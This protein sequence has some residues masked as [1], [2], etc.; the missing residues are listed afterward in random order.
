[1]Q[2][3]VSVLMLTVLLFVDLLSVV[4][5]GS[6]FEMWDSDTTEHVED[7][8]GPFLT[9]SGS[10]EVRFDPEKYT[11]IVERG[12][13]VGYRF[14][15]TIELYDVTWLFAWQIR[16]YF[17]NSVLNA[18]NAYYHPEEPIH[19]VPYAQVSPVIKNDY[20]ETHGYVQLAISALYPYYVNATAEDY[21]LGVGI[22]IME[23]E[24]LMKPSSGKNLESSLRLDNPSTM[25][26]KD[27]ST[28]ISCTKKNG[29][30]S[31]I[32]VA[33]K[34]PT[35]YATIQAAI[36]AADSGNTIFV[37]NGTYF[38]NVIINKTV[39]LFGQRADL[40]IVNGS[41]S[42]VL[43]GDDV[44][45]IIV[46]GFTL[47]F[48][49]NGA[50]FGSLSSSKISSCVIIDNRGHGI[51][52]SR[53][54]SNEILNNSICR[55]GGCGILGDS[56]ISG[57]FIRDNAIT[58]NGGSGISGRSTDYSYQSSFW[59][60]ENNNVSYNSGTGIEGVT[61]DR[62]KCNGWT[63]YN[64]AVVSNGGSGIAGSAREPRH[65]WPGDG[66]VDNWLVS[67]NTIDR[68]GGSGIC[69][70]G[71]TRTYCETTQFGYCKSWSV[72]RNNIEG[73]SGA[74]IFLPGY[75][76]QWTLSENNISSSQYG[77]WLGYSTHVLRKNH[78]DNST[79]NLRV[80][81]SYAQDID[82]SN[83]VNA[84]PIYYWV[85]KHFGQ[86]PS[87]A[88]YVALVNAS[89]I[90]VRDLDLSHN[91]QGILLA[92]LPSLSNITFTNVILSCNEKGVTLAQSSNFT[93]EDICSINNT[94]GVYLQDSV[95]CAIH[96]NDAINNTYGIFLES[97]TND[98]V[99]CN[100]LK[101]N[102]YG[103]YLSNSFNGTIYH[104]NFLC[105]T[106]QATIP[107]PKSMNTWGLDYPQGGN[108]WSNQAGP[109]W[110]KGIF[111][112]ETGSDGIVDTNVTINQKN[113][114]HYPLSAPWSW[115]IDI[116]VPGNTTCRGN[117]TSLIFTVDFSPSWIGYSL[118]GQANVTINENRTLTNLTYSCHRVIVYANDTLGNMYSS[119]EVHFTVTFL[120]D[121]NYDETVDINDLVE[122]TWRY[123]SVPGDARWNVY[124]DVNRDGIID[125][126]DIGMVANDYGKT[127]K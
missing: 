101:E 6:R 120:T 15:A 2:K 54:G 11:F 99:S 22:C 97:S 58:E 65:Y 119:A 118:D 83:T 121:I 80:D 90:I 61:Y 81:V 98:T 18:T 10:A 23:F 8:G 114:D 45:D 4:G 78:L 32:S 127:W 66:F 115:P 91:G 47:A 95:N 44:S 105:N 37:Y 104:N 36:N 109:D 92:N 67:R 73:N 57:V 34:V 50:R 126:V 12:V 75:D 14:N 94:Y 113:V 17:N 76:I 74:G 96:C 117:D 31:L 100:S 64:N 3:I 20:N 39:M 70:S 60:I 30:Y 9:A 53:G 38:E 35:D 62:G 46:D 69:A 42:D 77:I 29:S 1:M 110:C 106:H 89:N 19:T 86:V 13:D 72:S 28:I 79:Y 40:V 21:P 43:Y 112:N 5:V 124:A 27:P 82:S 111:Q 88:G 24:V 107:T 84:K 25:L 93:L 71:E 122:T 48:G 63:V 123:G 108:Y 51:S 85:D 68:N 55:N 116:L 16:V 41:G 49:G 26:R 52:L 56:G 59:V 33:I 103:L 87:D 125:V 102:V 7:V